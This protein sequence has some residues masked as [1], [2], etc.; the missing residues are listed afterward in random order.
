MHQK[1]E[2]N[3]SA[4]NPP[5]KDF[6]NEYRDKGAR[7]YRRNPGDN[8][9]RADRERPRIR[10]QRVDDGNIDFRRHFSTVSNHRAESKDDKSVT[11]LK[12]EQTLQ[13]LEETYKECSEENWDNYGAKP[14]SYRAYIEA[15]KINSGIETM[16]IKKL[17][18][19]SKPDLDLFSSVIF[20]L[21]FNPFFVSSSIKK[22]M[23]M[24]P[25]STHSNKL[26][27]KWYVLII[28][29]AG[30]NGLG[31]F[32]LPLPHSGHILISSLAAAS[33]KNMQFSLSINLSQFK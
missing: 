5:T 18:K 28:L 25:Q 1:A 7:R 27:T 22:N 13:Q 11:N 20:F 9:D 33:E 2:S 26:L 12:R 32:Q 14:I 3:H 30:F 4:S 17:D 6:V 31:N 10:I 16:L 23:P 8:R 29:F 21:V 24:W 15:E 19:C